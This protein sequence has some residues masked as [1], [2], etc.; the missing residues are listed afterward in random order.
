MSAI[1][2]MSLPVGRDRNGLLFPEI[3]GPRGAKVLA[4]AA[5]LESLLAG[6]PLT[7]PPKPDIA[8][9]KAAPLRNDVVFSSKANHKRGE[10]I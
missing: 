2:A 1:P 7:A 5:A 4:V 9:L 3:V 8:R 10:T 6:D